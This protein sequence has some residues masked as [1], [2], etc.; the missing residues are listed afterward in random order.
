M[1]YE[2]KLWEQFKQQMPVAKEKKKEL[3]ADGYTGNKLFLVI[4]GKMGGAHVY[5]PSGAA[6]IWTAAKAWGM[7]PTKAEIH[8]AMTA[9]K[10]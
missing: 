8:Q 4:H 9:R 3:R 7:D 6:A 10:C 1:K 5:A 2:E